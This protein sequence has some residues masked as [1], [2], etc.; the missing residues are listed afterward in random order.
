MKLK[1]MNLCL[2][3]A[4]LTATSHGALSF[5][6]DFSSNTAG[7]NMTLGTP[8]TNPGSTGPVTTSF[9]G[10]FQVTSGDGNRIYLGTNDTDYSTVDFSFE[11]DATIINRT[12][13]SMAFLGMG[14]TVPS[15]VVQVPGEPSGN[16]PNV[17]MVLRPDEGTGQ[18]Q[19]RNDGSV[20]VQGLA[21]LGMPF[22]S[23]TTFGMRMN[24]NA[25]TKVATFLFDQTND[26]TYESSR[27]QTIT[28][29]DTGFNGA[30]SRLFVGGGA[31]L[32][33]DNIVINAVPEPSAALLGG[34]GALALLRRRRN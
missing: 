18:L 22:T 31:G 20:A 4:G 9:T 6:E 26:G 13:W 7:P 11:A 25:T 28:R 30:N 24:W 15:T 32:S 3:M 19:T 12:A 16:S 27:T 2:V 1:S 14:D 10:A 8:F 33:F 21:D 23:P 29:T 17:M 34:L 5:T